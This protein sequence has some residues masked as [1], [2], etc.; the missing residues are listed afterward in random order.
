MP[1]PDEWEALWREHGGRLWRSI[2]AFCGNRDAAD[3]AVAEAFAQALR[4]GAAIRDR[5]AWIWR[6][7]FRIAGGEMAA[8]RRSVG[9]VPDTPVEEEPVVAVMEALRRLPWRQR[10]AILLHHYAGFSVREVAVMIDSTP[11]AVKMNLSRGRR[12]LRGLLGDD[13]G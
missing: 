6:T 11:A 8:R 10:A 2:Y 3:D 12:R 4:R 13:D 5:P 9:P 7:A 1:V